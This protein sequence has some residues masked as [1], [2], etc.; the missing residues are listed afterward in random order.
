MMNLQLPDVWKVTLS[1]VMPEKVFTAN[2][3]AREMG[4]H[5]MRITRAVHR[6]LITPDY[7]AGRTLLFRQSRLPKIRAAIGLPVQIP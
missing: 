1:H 4:V 2:S 6:H 5:Q 3:L 7:L